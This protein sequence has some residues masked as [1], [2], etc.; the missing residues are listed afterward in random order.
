MEIPYVAAC[1]NPN[2]ALSIASFGWVAIN[3]GYY[4]CAADVLWDAGTLSG[5]VGIFGVFASLELRF[6]QNLT[7]KRIYAGDLIDGVL[8]DITDEV[9]VSKNSLVL[10]KVLIEKYSFIAKAR[11][12]RAIGRRNR[13]NASMMSNYRKRLLS[14][15]TALALVCALPLCANAAVNL[16]PAQPCE[17][18]NYVCTWQTQETFE[19]VRD[20]LCDANLF[21]ETG[22]VNTTALFPEEVRAD[23][24]FLLDDGWD[25]PYTSNPDWEDYF[26][27]FLLDEAKFPDYG[28]SQR[29][30]LKTLVDKVRA[31]GWKGV[32]VWVAMDEHPASYWRERL[33]WCKYAGITYWKVDWGGVNNSDGFRRQLSRLAKQVY[34]ELVM[35]HT[36]VIGPING[37][38]AADVGNPERRR[39]WA[40]RL[41]YS[42]VYRTYDYLHELATATTL[43]RTAALLQDAY[44]KNTN[45]SAL[46][47]LNGEDNL[48][49]NAALGMTSGVMRSW[50]DGPYGN[51]FQQ[52]RP[53]R[54]CMAEIGRMLRWQRIAP[55][56]RADAYPVFISDEIL[57]DAHYIAPMWYASASDKVV[58]QRAPAALSRGITLPAVTVE[59]GDKPFVVA[60]RNPNGAIS[61]ATLGRTSDEAHY[62]TNPA[63]DVSLDV[64]DL[65][66]KVG[67][68]GV[69]GSLTLTFNQSLADKAILAQDL[70]ADEAQEITARVIINGNAL[71]IPGALISEIGTSQNPAG[72]SSE[73]GLV[74][75]IGNATDFV[76][77]PQ[78]R[79]ACPP[80]G[81]LLHGAEIFRNSPKAADWLESGM[82]QG[83]WPKR[84][85]YYILYGLLWPGA[86]IAGG[87]CT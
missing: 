60:S 21:G 30:R 62:H 84:I 47:L 87:V 82:W 74:L 77:P 26:S 43:E 85:C 5:P 57:E 38:E 64:G 42:D 54:H 53:L 19:G 37:P 75:Q 83:G 24:L 51:E 59:T 81:A 18:P 61:I 41:S 40:Y 22:W 1:R 28:E 15:L 86:F 70:L 50:H 48:Y 23:A 79:K 10:S 67:I 31:C 9:S 44:S 35:E 29:E 73:P 16:V 39:E 12:C 72:D 6:N 14:L 56:F 27:S 52:S 49:L 69:Y 8:Y 4:T 34:P 33:E 45:G 20:A 68:F 78:V 11:R 17:S 76:S 36:W 66:G 13:G 80:F 63:A 71:T 3:K 2:G 32:G 55:A 7:G 46:N 65:T 25:L 58:T